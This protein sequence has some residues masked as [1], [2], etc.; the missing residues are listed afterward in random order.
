M[1]KHALC[2]G[3]V[4]HKRY[5]PK[6]HEFSYSLNCWLINLQSIETLNSN[7][8]LINSA[9]RAIY[10]FKPD[11][12]LRDFDGQLLDKVKAK[13][14]ELGAYLNGDE[15][16]FLLG[17]VSNLGVYFSP[18]NLYFCYNNSKCSFILAEV[19]NTPWNER[20]Y[21]LLDMNN[22][23]ITS[24]KN[25]HVSPFFG[26]NQEYHW[27]FNLNKN[28]ISFKINSYQEKTLVFSASYTGDLNILSKRTTIK[29]IILSPIIVYK[30]VTAIYFEAL[31]IW[32][33]KIPFVPYPDKLKGK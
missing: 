18:L 21:Y 8:W 12:Y 32:L 4:W 22:T 29:K 33:K 31:F 27:N 30:I 13:L 15:Q 23:Q 11:N 7:S 28:K 17:Q 5:S 24:K 6:I 10:K 20:Y 14:I 19:S 26:L 16:F 9:K 2:T 25:F 3:K 1:F